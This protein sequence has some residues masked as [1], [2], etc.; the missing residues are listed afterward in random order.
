MKMITFRDVS[1]AP[2]EGMNKAGDDGVFA[3]TSRLYP[4]VKEEARKAASDGDFPWEDLRQTSSLV[5]CHI[6]QL[7]KRGQRSQAGEVL[8]FFVTEEKINKAAKG[9]TLVSFSAG[10]AG[11]LSK[12]GMSSEEIRSLFGFDVLSKPAVAEWIKMHDEE[13]RGWD[14]EKDPRLAAWRE[15]AKTVSA[16]YNTRPLPERVEFLPDP[17]A[18]DPRGDAAILPLPGREGY[19]ILR[20]SAGWED[21]IYSPRAPVFVADALKGQKFN[22]TCVYRTSL[23]YEEIQQ[24]FLNKAGVEVVDKTIRRK[25]WVAKYD[26][27]KL[28]Y[29]RAVPPLDGSSLGSET[30]TRGG[31]AQTTAASLLEIFERMA[32]SGR[33]DVPGKGSP[34]MIVD[35]TGLPRRPG[36]NQTWGSICLTYSYAFW[37]GEEATKLAKKWFEENF[38]ITFH[39]E[40]RDVPAKEIRPVSSASAASN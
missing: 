7:L 11:K 21:F 33:E 3:L 4:L 26:G 27:R 20:L 25:V 5:P 1:T 40:E 8:R 36:K 14:P 12:A 22:A 37:E 32:N 16:R 6:E 10:V 13:S 2:E 39:E 18:F 30:V 23:K 35:E 31:G 19:S 24:A 28:P 9:H 34:I 29:W 38:G 17:E 15:Y